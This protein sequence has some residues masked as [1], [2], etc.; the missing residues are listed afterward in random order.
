MRKQRLVKCVTNQACIFVKSA[1]FKITGL[2]SLVFYR[3]QTVAIPLNQL[4][5][6]I[7]AYYN[8]CVVRVPVTEYHSIVVLLS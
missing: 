5:V 2:L 8:N 4:A 3:G 7:V 1:G 6:V